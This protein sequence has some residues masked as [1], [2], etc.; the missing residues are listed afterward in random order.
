[1]VIANVIT[2]VIVYHHVRKIPNVLVEKNVLKMNVDPF[3][4]HVLR[5]LKDKYAFAVYAFQDVTRIGIVAKKC[6]A[7]QS[8]AFQLVRKILVAKMQLVS[9]LDIAQLAVAL[10]DFQEILSMNVNHMNVLAMKSVPLMRNVVK[11]E[12]AKMFV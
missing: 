8:Y 6:V 12:N 7:H 1:M 10:A 9:Q 2:V 11:R 3:V 4:P 5:V